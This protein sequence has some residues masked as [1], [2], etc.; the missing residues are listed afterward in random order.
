[1]RIGFVEP[2]IVGAEGED[3]GKCVFRFISDAALGFIFVAL[4]HIS[5]SIAGNAQIGE[6]VLVVALFPIEEKAEHSAPATLLIIPYSVGSGGAKEKI[7]HRFY[8]NRRVVFSCDRR[9]TGD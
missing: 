2:S 7:V 8:L 4:K 3:G 6:G 9:L 5:G 1:M